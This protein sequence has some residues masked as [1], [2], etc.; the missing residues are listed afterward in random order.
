MPHCFCGNQKNTFRSCFSSSTVGSGDLSQVTRLAHTFICWVIFHSTILYCET[1]SPA[2]HKAEGCARLTAKSPW[3]RSVSAPSAEF[4]GMCCH[5]GFLGEHWGSK[6]RSHDCSASALPIEPLFYPKRID[7]IRA[8]YF[9]K[10]QQGI[11]GSSAYNR[12]SRCWDVPGITAQALLFSGAV[13][14]ISLFL[15]ILTSTLPQ[16]P[17][18]GSGTKQYYQLHKK[19]YG[20]CKN[21][22]ARQCPFAKKAYAMIHTGLPV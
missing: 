2:Q 15:S 19:I 5:H 9:T 4:T 7:F 6:L 11:W 16:L 17:H 18:T 21:N 22:P 12:S 13:L 8:L 10:R 3:D 14:N 1:V 20:Q